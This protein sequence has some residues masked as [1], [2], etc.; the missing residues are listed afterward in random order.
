MRYLLVDD[1]PVSNLV[2]ELNI[3]KFDAQADIVIFSCP[4]NSIEIYSN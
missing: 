2:S 3:K 4:K 1:D